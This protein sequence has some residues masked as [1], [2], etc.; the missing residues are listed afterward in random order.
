MTITKS[1]DAPENALT[2][3]MQSSK[4][5]DVSLESSSAKEVIYK[6]PLTE[7]SNFPKLFAQLE[8]RKM[9]LGV[10]SIGVS[11]TTMEQVFLK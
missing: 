4:V 8:G 10:E 9:E 2:N 5:R 1:E 6:L 3:V 7:T 11:C